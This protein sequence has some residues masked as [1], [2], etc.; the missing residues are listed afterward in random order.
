MKNQEITKYINYLLQE[1]RMTK[2]TLALK[3]GKTNAEI[4]KYLKGDFNFK[5]SV[6]EKIEEALSTE[7]ISVKKT[8]INNWSLS[9][10]SF[11]EFNEKIIWK[12]FSNFNPKLVPSKMGIYF[13]KFKN[14]YDFK[15]LDYD[16]PIVY[17]GYTIN[18][19]IGIQRIYRGNN[20]SQKTNFR[21]HNCIQKNDCEVGYVLVE[22]NGREVKKAILQDFKNIYGRLP[23]ENKNQ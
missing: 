19:K 20:P 12:D 5:L 9:N 2:S 3:I 10:G 18:L 4:T 1:K 13:F 8:P 22:E 14:K 17:I 6:I 11:E 16:S 21:L 23:K 15:I 7:I